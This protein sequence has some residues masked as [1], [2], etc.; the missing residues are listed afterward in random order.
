MDWFSLG[1]SAVSL[2][3]QSLVHVGFL[4]R[5]TGRR[6]RAGY[7]AG[8]LALLAAFQGLLTALG[9]GL[10]PAAALELAALYAGSRLVLRNGPA[11]S[12][13]AA[14]L[15]VYVFQLA[16]GAVNSLEAL[17]VPRVAKGLPL[18]ALVT[19]AA[20]AAPALSWACCRVILGLLTAEEARYLPLPGLF[21]LAAELYI[22]VTA[23]SRLPAGGEGA[24]RHLALLLLQ[25]LGLA[26][27]LCTLY[28]CRR[29][30]RGIRAQA[31][32]DSLA[33]SVQAQKTYVAEARTR[34][35][36]T[37]SFRHDLQNHLSVLDGLLR[38]GRTAEARDYLRRLE[39]AASALSPPCRTGDPAV[40]VLLGEKL[41]LAR[42]RGIDAEAAVRLPEGVDGFDLCVIFANALD[43]A[44]A[45]CAAEEGA[46][47]RVWDRRQG[48]WY[49]LFFENSCRPGPGVRPGTGLANI[50]AAAE[51]YRGTA[52][53]RQEG[54]R[55]RLDVLLNISGQPENS[56]ERSP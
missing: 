32:L 12:C 10:L 20:L 18:Y 52:S 6:A 26:A 56:S 21:F 50:R 39:S 22:L 46:F 28:V 7:F 8:Y 37:K 49:G 1:L 42:D 44:L 30:C 43:N 29:A 19:L 36:R 53:F 51:K 17:A 27:L 47:L 3:S 54:G 41:T 11:L 2:A 31:A 34:Y 16:S 48:D 9:G 13:A 24:G 35:E 5:L 23:Y 45:A 4:C 14:A 25:L 33:Q 15:A 55:F 40:D 38:D